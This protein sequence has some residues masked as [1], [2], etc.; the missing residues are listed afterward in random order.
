MALGC[1]KSF[2]AFWSETLGFRMI[3]RV[4]KIKQVASACRLAPARG[5]W[6]PT[7]VAELQWRWRSDLHE[8]KGE[9]HVFEVKLPEC[10]GLLV[11]INLQRLVPLAWCDWQGTHLGVPSIISYVNV[12]FVHPLALWKTSKYTLDLLHNTLWVILKFVGMIYLMWK[13]PCSNVLSYRSLHYRP[14]G[15]PW[16]Y[17]LHL[18]GQ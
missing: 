17:N 12:F 18:L 14:V 3:L 15:L 16:V 13:F 7:S 1:C 10:I 6:G 5:F 2:L 11:W 4:Q 8:S 9:I